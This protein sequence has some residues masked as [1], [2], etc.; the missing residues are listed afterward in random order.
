MTKLHHNNT[1]RFN[2]TNP[3]ALRSMA[4]SAT[5]EESI[6]WS[7]MPEPVQ[8]KFASFTKS[9]MA[10][11]TRLRRDACARRASNICVGKKKRGK[12][13]GG[14]KKKEREKN[15]TCFGSKKNAE[16]FENE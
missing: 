13:Y 1:T 16:T 4:T 11:R 14:K 6:A 3:S 12:D 7:A 10:S 8:S 2:N 15:P 5:C 9:L